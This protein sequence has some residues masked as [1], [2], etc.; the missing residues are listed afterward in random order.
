MVVGTV[1]SPAGAGGQAALVEAKTEPAGQAGAAVCGAGRAASLSVADAQAVA[2]LQQLIAGGGATPAR[3]AR[4]SKTGSPGP[5]RP[6]TPGGHGVCSGGGGGGVDACLFAA[7]AQVRRVPRG[8][9]TGGCGGTWRACSGRAS[10]ELVL[11][12]AWRA[13][14]SGAATYMRRIRCAGL[15]LLSMMREEPSLLGVLYIMMHGWSMRMRLA[16]P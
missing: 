8:A 10:N 12:V 15:V 2:A 13:G 6:V 11:C 5:G 1:V 16:A 7:G 4:A 3:A 9:P 14:G